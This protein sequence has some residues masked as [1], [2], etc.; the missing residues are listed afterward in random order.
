MRVRFHLLTMIIGSLVA[1]WYLYLNMVYEHDWAPH[2]WPFRIFRRYEYPGKELFEFFST[3]AL[4]ST[5]LVGLTLVI[6]VMIGVEVVLLIRRDGASSLLRTIKTWIPSRADIAITLPFL[7][8]IIVLNVVASEK[9]F[10]VIS[11]GWPVTV[12]WTGTDTTG[13]WHYF[14]MYRFLVLDVYCWAAFVFIPMAIAELLIR[15]R[16]RSGP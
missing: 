11:Y 15:R 1:G 13:D 9:S 10:D 14:N 6:S 2:G 16:R 12:M 3:P 8:A 5:I 4:I 7:I